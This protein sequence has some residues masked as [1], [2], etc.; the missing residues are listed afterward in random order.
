MT[1]RCEDK[2]N[3]DSITTGIE[4][5]KGEQWPALNTSFFSF[6]RQSTQMVMDDGDAVQQHSDNKRHA[7]HQRLYI[8]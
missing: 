5:N 1:P 6:S 3:V 4:E 2:G 7:I 8:S